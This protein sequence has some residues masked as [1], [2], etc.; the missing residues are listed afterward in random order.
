[1]KHTVKKLS[2]GISAAAAVLLCG[3]AMPF[4]ASAESVEDVYEAMRRIGLPESMV[5]EAKLQYQNTEHDD[6]GMKINDT[7]L[8]YDVWSDMVELYED[9]IWNEVGKQFGV[10]GEEIKQ[11]SAAEPQ[12][13]AQ[14]QPPAAASTESGKTAPAPAQTEAPAKPAVSVEPA[15]PF[16]N[17]TLDEKKEY[18]ASLPENERAGFIAGLSNTER[19]SVI[20]QMSTESQANIASGFIQ[21][22]EQFGMHISVDQLDGSGINYSV[23]NSDGTLI[24]V[25]SVGTSV[26]DTGWNTTVPVLGGSAM[27]LGAVGGLILLTRRQRREGQDA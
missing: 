1:M 25:S 9:D 21:L 15:K 10:T 7:Y 14:T 8:T 26:D 20:K 5:Q 6:E 12:Q 4:A 16:I 22:G 24:D 23:R 2:A 19:N 11:A 18:V 13:P 27:I 17:M 3:A